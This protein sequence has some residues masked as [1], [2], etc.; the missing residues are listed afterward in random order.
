MVRKF[1]YNK[2]FRTTGMLLL[3]LLLILFP[4][5]KEYSLDDVTTKTTYI[6]KEKV[7]YLIDKNNYVARCKVNIT[8]YTNEEYAIKVLELLKLDGKYSNLIPNGFKA[9]LPSDLQV[10]KVRI[11]DNKIVIDLSP[12]LL[13]IKEE[14]EKIIL[15]LIT[16]NLTEIPGIE[17]VY[18]NINGNELNKFNSGNVIN[19]PLT[20]KNGINIDSNI[21]NYK[22]AKLLTI[23]YV[24]KNHDGYYFIPVS[25]VTNDTKEDIKIIVDELKQAPIN[26]KGLMSFLNYNAQLIDY[27]IENDKITLNFNDFLYDDEIEKTVSEEVINSIS[28][29]MKDNYDASE[30]VFN[31]NGNEII[32]SVIKNIE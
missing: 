30:V 12:E 13:N 4:V 19:M 7:V 6:K 8:A 32:K 11:D 31:I 22:D 17:E 24:N 1:A 25:K 9:I 14:Y 23:Y 28:L 21:Y 16:Y 20:R 3:F 2:I 15:E 5:S 10:N 18:I 26:Q 27:N 29:S